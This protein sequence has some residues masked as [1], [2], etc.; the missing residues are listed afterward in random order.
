ML[1]YRVLRVTYTNECVC[2]FVFIMSITYNVIKST[3]M[4]EGNKKKMK[5]KAKTYIETRFLN[6]LLLYIFIGTS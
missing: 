6:I 1:Y 2:V 4:E 5:K 3:V